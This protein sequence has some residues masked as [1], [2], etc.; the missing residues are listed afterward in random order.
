MGIESG[1]SPERAYIKKINESLEQQQE[2]TLLPPRIKSL[3]TRTTFHA[4]TSPSDILLKRVQE[5]DKLD[6]PYNNYKIRQEGTIISNDLLTRQHLVNEN[7]WLNPATNNRIADTTLRIT[8]AERL[9]GNRLA[10]VVGWS[11]TTHFG[12]HTGHAQA[13]IELCKKTVRN[14]PQ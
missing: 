4:L 10:N 12:I 1:S 8:Y 14:L 5:L 3:V 13:A 11:P 7:L 2:W 6:N 9:I